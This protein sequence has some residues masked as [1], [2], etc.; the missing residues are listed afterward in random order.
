MA[1]RLGAGI[2]PD[3]GTARKPL[4]DEVTELIGRL[5]GL[6]VAQRVRFFATV[7]EDE[8]IDTYLHV[9]LL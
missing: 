7:A 6:T 8:T 1:A 5:G 4:E 2:G 3:P 9:Q